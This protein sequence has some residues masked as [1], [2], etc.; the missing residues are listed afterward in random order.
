[1]QDLNVSSHDLAQVFSILGIGF[2][3]GFLLKKYVRYFFVVSIALLF[4]F[5]IFDRFGVIIVDWPHLQQ[6][7]GIDPNSTIQHYAE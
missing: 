6:L 3:S 4:I 2:F 7:T 1:M 5:M